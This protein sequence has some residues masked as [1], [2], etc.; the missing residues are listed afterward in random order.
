M[1]LHRR[2][3]RAIG[4]SLE[5]ARRVVLQVQIDGRTFLSLALPE[6]GLVAVLRRADSDGVDIEIVEPTRR[7]D[8][9]G[10]SEL[11]A[12]QHQALEKP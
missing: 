7:T 6:P 2:H 8:V 3:Y 11:A 4:D 9:G 5:K 1:A 10:E 12:W